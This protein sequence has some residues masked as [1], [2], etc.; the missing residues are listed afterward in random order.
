MCGKCGMQHLTANY[1]SELQREGGGEVNRE[2]GAHIN[3]ANC[4][5]KMDGRR[6]AQSWWQLHSLTDIETA[7]DT[8]G[9]TDTDTD[10]D[11]ETD[12]DRDTNT[13]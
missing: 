6:S 1:N 11:T 3:A 5:A 8:D 7:K 12:T 13:E 10:G 9:D 4:R 2:H